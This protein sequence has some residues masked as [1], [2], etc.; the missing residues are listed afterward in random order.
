MTTTR[1]ALGCA[2]GLL[3][4]A[5]GVVFLSARPARASHTIFDY[6][7]DHAEV[8]GQPYGA[9][10]GTPDFTDEFNDG[11]PAP[12]GDMY[13]GTV[14]ES[15]GLIHLTNPGTD[16]GGVVD[17]SVSP[18]MGGV[19][20]DG[21]GDVCFTAVWPPVSIPTNG[22]ALAAFGDG[23]TF[24]GT[25]I[26]LAN[27]DADAAA[28]FGIP[29]GLSIV[30]GH[31]SPALSFMGVSIM[32]SDITG[33]VHMRICLD[34]AADEWNTAISLDGG[35]TF[36]TPFA[37]VPTFLTSSGEGVSLVAGNFTVTTT[38][39]TSSTN[40]S[41]STTNTTST[42][43]TSTSST[44]TTTVPPIPGH[45]ECYKTKDP[46]PKVPYT[47]DLLAG[48]GGYDDEIGCTVKAGAKLICV[49][50]TKQNVSPSPPGGGPVVP[51]NA[52]SIFLSYKIKCPPTTRPPALLGDQF[53]SS[54]FDVRTAAELLVPAVPTPA[55]DH[56]KCY[57]VKDPRPKVSY[58]LDLVDQAGFDDQLGCSLK[59]G[60]KRICA[61]VT[62][63]NVS[64]VPP[65]GGPGPGPNSGAQFL[66][67]KVKC[68]TGA[69]PFPQVHDQFGPTGT[70]IPGSAKFLLVPAS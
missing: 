56:Y 66:S 40:T 60:A 18:L 38:T 52:G 21:G 20:T 54:V 42:T 9:M 58:T 15:G 55:L 3:V 7:F 23:N 12:W 13:L 29:S 28:S 63:Q 59:L 2:T 11:V 16:V 37:P 68:P 24:E 57:K 32:E 43:A 48:V 65:P 53:G 69:V 44:A 6:G 26:G 34:D 61:Q 47:L 39:T 5:S 70:F 14:S 8:D 17:W 67:Y 19:A 51:P 31:T 49:E 41:T 64:P 36:L 4:I 10:D 35:A 50:T 1:K 33:P 25:G 45:L 46:R 30:L 27:P 62:K 22:M